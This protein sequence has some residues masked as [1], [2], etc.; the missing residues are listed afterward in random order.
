M[1]GGA[2]GSIWW[3][4]SAGPRHRPHRRRWAALTGDLALGIGATL[5]DELAQSCG[6]LVDDGL[7]VDALKHQPSRHLCRG[8][9][10]APAPCLSGAAC[11]RNL[12]PPALHQ[13]AAAAAAM[14]TASRRRGSLV[15]DRPVRHQLSGG[16][17]IDAAR[18]IERHGPGERLMLFGLDTHGVLTGAVAVA[19][20]DMR[21]ARKLIEQG[22]RPIP[23][24]WPTMPCRCAR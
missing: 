15:L 4:Q 1:G 20:A 11:G 2:S 19:G 24:R 5:N 21:H 6:L 9:C 13:G 14:V 16:G 18:W 17:R 12:G 8:R 23:P 7:A 22:W 10:C 3:R